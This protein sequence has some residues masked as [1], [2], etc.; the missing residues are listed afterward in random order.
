MSIENDQV[1]P[2]TRRQRDLTRKG[3]DLATLHEVAAIVNE[4]NRRQ[5]EYFDQCFSS[6][7]LEYEDRELRRNPI[8]NKIKNLFRKKAT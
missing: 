1:I 3:N 7:V 2:A 5:K 8:A 4:G 6:F